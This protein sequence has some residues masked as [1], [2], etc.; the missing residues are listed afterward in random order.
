MALISYITVTK[1]NCINSSVAGSFKP[2]QKRRYTS[3]NNYF[4]FLWYQ[5]T[6]VTPIY[7]S[8]SASLRHYAS[9]CEKWIFTMSR[10]KVTRNTR[11]ERVFEL[12]ISFTHYLFTPHT[13]EAHKKVTCGLKAKVARGEKWSEFTSAA[14]IRIIGNSLRNMWPKYNRERDF[15]SKQIN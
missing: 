7:N 1:K 12:E 3:I 4:I 5:T 15:K 11:Y 14:A 10:F 2:L 13:D 8:C 9:C 6:S